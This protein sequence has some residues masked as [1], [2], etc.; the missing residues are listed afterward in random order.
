MFCDFND[1]FTIAYYICKC[2]TLVFGYERVFDSVFI[3]FSQYNFL[4]MLWF[5][6]PIPCHSPQQ[7]L[8]G[9]AKPENWQ[10]DTSTRIRM[11]GLQLAGMK[12]V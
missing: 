7:N 6:L 10:T 11:V 3:F 12:N 8:E 9:L 2:F 1:I 5:T 4:W